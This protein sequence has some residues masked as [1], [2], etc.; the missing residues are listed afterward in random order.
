MATTLTFCAAILVCVPALD[1]PPAPTPELEPNQT[2][3]TATPAI[4]AATNI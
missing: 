3:D 4:P 2:R 1:T